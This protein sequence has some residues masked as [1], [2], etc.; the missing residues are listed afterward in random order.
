MTSSVAANAVEIARN[1]V[2][3]PYRHQASCRGGGTDCLGLVRGVWRD[4]YGTEP[5]FV[6]P[7]TPDWSEA[8]NEEIL[9]QAARRHL[10]EK[11]RQD[12]AYGDVVLF[13]MRDRSVAKHIGIVAAAGPRA[14]FIHAYSGHGVIESPLGDAWRRRIAALFSFPV[15]EA[16]DQP[17][18]NN[19]DTAWRR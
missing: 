7:Y 12:L 1:W 3:T 6:P 8:A 15:L 13:R 11:P 16:A 5:E 9:W 4:L 10:I 14:R 2:G 17:I 19:E 18:S